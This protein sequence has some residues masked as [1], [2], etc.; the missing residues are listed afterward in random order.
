MYLYW[1]ESGRESAML[2]LHVA[3]RSLQHDLLV[4]VKSL[5]TE[6]NRETLCK[7]YR[8]NP[9]NVNFYVHQEESL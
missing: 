2:F 5:S 1:L 8:N 4:P 9:F 3:L 7:S 6:D